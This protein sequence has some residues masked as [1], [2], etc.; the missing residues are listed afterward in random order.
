MFPLIG[1]FTGKRNKPILKKLY[2]SF[3]PFDAEALRELCE[4][5]PEN[6]AALEVGSWL[7]QGS[8]QVLIAAAKRKN[9]VVY[10]VDTWRG[11]PNVVKHQKIVKKYD[12]FGTFQANVQ[13]GGGDALV[14]SLVMPA[15]DAAQ[16][17]SDHQFD[18][19]FIDADHSYQAT[20]SD[21]AKWRNKV[22]PGGILC[23]HDC[24]GRVRDFDEGLLQRSINLDTIPGNQKFKAIHPGVVLATH[25]VFADTH[26]LFAEKEL[27]LPS[28]RSGRST[29]WYALQGL[30]ISLVS[31][32]DESAPGY[33]GYLAC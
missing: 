19:V 33:L 2:P 11:S 13:A 24:E 15:D 32:V 21:I 1:L 20:K 4:E 23:G 9:G 7:G 8:T 3:T 28:G 6:F 10:C 26:H 27:H 30:L 18:L 31:F 16:I 29:I 22:K 17:I 25:E 5:L 14:K 12:V